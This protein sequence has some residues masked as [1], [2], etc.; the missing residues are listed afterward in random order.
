MVILSLSKLAWQQNQRSN[1]TPHSQCRENYLGNEIW[2]LSAPCSPC[3]IQI[4]LL[5][6]VWSF[7][8][9]SRSQVNSR[10][11][12]KTPGTQLI[13]YW[14]QP[15]LSRT[16]GHLPSWCQSFSRQGPGLLLSVQ[17]CGPPKCV[18]PVLWVKTWALGSLT[19]FPVCSQV[20][21]GWIGVKAQLLRHYYVIKNAVPDALNSLEVLK[22]LGGGSDKQYI[23]NTE[24]TAG[25]TPLP[26]QQPYAMLA[27]PK[28]F[29]SSWALGMGKRRHVSGYCQGLRSSSQF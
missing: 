6:C 7:Q 20:R 18:L 8:F 12:L 13:R 16:A 24:C 22:T 25:S 21:H 14:A 10:R 27:M 3:D 19:T 1:L 17:E 9:T 2:Y 23:A 11:L 29:P 15:S 28:I 4:W 26:E 5:A